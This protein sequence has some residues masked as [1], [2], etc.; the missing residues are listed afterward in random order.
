M[1][2]QKDEDGNIPIMTALEA[3]NVALC[4]ELLSLNLDAQIRSIKVGNPTSL[5]TN[6]LG[7]YIRY[8]SPKSIN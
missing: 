8:P 7:R 2:L 3:N 6:V 4:H 1:P 5:A